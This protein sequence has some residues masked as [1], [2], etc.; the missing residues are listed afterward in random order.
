MLY[1]VAPYQDQPATAINAGIIDHG[2]S[3]LA[4]TRARVAKPLAPKP[5]DQPKRQRQQRKHGHEC[6]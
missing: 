2:K 6:E 1:V 5:P 4:T 3:R